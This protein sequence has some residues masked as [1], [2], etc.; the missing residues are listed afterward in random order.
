MPVEKNAY[1][2]ILNEIISIVEKSKNQLVVQANSALTLTFWHIGNR[3]ITEVL[4]NERAAYGKQIVVTLSRDLEKI[5]GR[6]FNEKNL[7]RMI[8]F[9]QKFPDPEI[10]VTLSRQLSWSHFLVLLPLKT[11]KD[12][13]FYGKL[14]AENNFGVR[15]LRKQISKKNI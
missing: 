3:I 6:T 14:V 1:Q 5:F 9:A 13:L 4:K 15:E 8:Q 2:K 7:G 10:V 12:R 11:N